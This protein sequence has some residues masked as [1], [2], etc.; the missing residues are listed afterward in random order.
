M[1]KFS[2]AGFKDPVRR[3][4]YIVWTGVV[5]LVLAVVVVFALGATSTRW[6][7]AQVCHSVQDD[8][9]AAYEASTHS[10]ISCMAC[11]EPVNADT[12]TFL[13][14]KVKS[15]LEVIPT[16]RNTYELPLNPGS[17]LS[18]K[19][20]KEMGSQQCTQ[21]H[22]KN[23]EVT[24]SK[25][26]IIDHAVHEEKDVW[27][28]VCHNRI[29]HNEEAAPPTLTDPR[30]EKNK[31]HPDFMKMDGCFRCHD[32]EGK[33]TAPGACSACHTADFPLKPANHLK[34]EFYPK[35]HAELAR[36]HEKEFEEVAKEAKILEEEGIRKDLAAPVDYCATC[37]IKSKFC[38]SCHG[39]EIPHPEE[40]KTKTHPQVVKTS[41][42][43]CVMC[44]GEPA[45]TGFCSDCHHG[46]KIGWTFDVKVPWKN[47]HA[48]AVTKNGIDKCFVACHDQQFCLDC[49]TKTKPLPTS[50]KA[51]NWL[52]R[53]NADP[54]AKDKA[55]HA[56]N[57]TS[58]IKA[59]E[60]CH[61]VGGTASAFCVGCHKQPMPH[62]ADF[63]SF[64][65]KTGR[66][67]PAVCAN[68]HQFKE[69]CSNCHHKGSLTTTGWLPLH[70]KVVA[71]TG[72]ASGCFAKCHKKDFCVACHT[73]RKVVPAS[74]KAADWTKRASLDSKA[75]H[76]ALFAKDKE[77]CT[78]CH[79]DGGTSSAFC[80]GCHKLPMPHPSGF[81]P[82]KGATLEVGK[83]GTHEADLKTKK[84]TNAQ[85]VTCHV[86][87][88]CDKC[89]H[90]YTGAAP[91]RTAHDD[92]VKTS[93]PQKCFKCHKETYCSYCHVRLIP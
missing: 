57:A 26:I 93:D 60:I 50:H 29:A 17:A 8:S 87:Q 64:H 34:A 92:I 44:H 10:E 78:Y 59:C 32:L 12:V 37:H 16:V 46:K 62:P 70:G 30:G 20:G 52:H 45:T 68:C 14:A 77:N 25:G 66:A 76:S 88:F 89:H 22:S 55:V 85:C 61:G 79:G 31:R 81:G 72:N 40:F 35:G 86:Q 21:C 63:K 27:C 90:E 5:V 75:Q 39:M 15:G 69:L 58:N 56:A 80:T 84:L 48:T 4:R 24:P 83:G 54:F 9:I 74:H 2:L 28:T 38:D 3:P 53:A 19:G 73:G 7:C 71:Q 23:R 51:A 41:F 1:A 42:A 33:K 91:W 36:E 13:L 47:Q 82:A 11:H 65:A 6:F 67:N 18:L 43:K 49:H